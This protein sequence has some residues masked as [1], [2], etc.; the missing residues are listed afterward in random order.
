MRW[1]PRRSLGAGLWSKGNQCKKREEYP[2]LYD[3]RNRKGNKIAGAPR[4]FCKV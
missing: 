3:E 1:Y 2:E 4:Q